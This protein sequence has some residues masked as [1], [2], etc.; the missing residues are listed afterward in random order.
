MPVEERSVWLSPPPPP[1]VLKTMSAVMRPLLR[2]PLGRRVH[3][4]MLLEFRGRR[5]G[6]A[7][8]VPV[9]FNL[10]DDVPM[11]FTGA[12]WRQNFTGGFPVTVTHRG[13]VHQ[14]TG[15]LV[16]MTPEEMGAAVRKSL[17]TGGSAQ[18]MGIKTARDHEATAAQLA[19]L[20]PALGTSVIRFEFR[21][22]LP[23][24]G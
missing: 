5:T 13:H 2:S 7:M 14:T 16:P 9:N 15:T 18:R 20:G 12:A 10:V 11:A 19:G 24:G 8:S 3:G 6:R 17:D 4:V 21:P 23:G 22:S 1:A